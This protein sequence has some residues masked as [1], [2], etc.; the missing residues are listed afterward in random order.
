MSRTI[1]CVLSETARFHEVPAVGLY[2][3]AVDASGAGLFAGSSFFSV[4]Q[5]EN[6]RPRGDKGG[7]ERAEQHLTGVETGP[8]RPTRQVVNRTSDRPP[9]RASA[10]SQSPSASQ[11]TGL[12][13]LQELNLRP[14]H[15]EKSGASSSWTRVDHFGK[16]AMLKSD[17]GNSVL[18]FL[19]MA[20]IQPWDRM[21]AV[22]HRIWSPRMGQVQ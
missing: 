20:R 22:H 8:V 14:V 12:L 5:A 6:Q 1:R 4:V 19:S 16:S 11:G 9:D 10:M 2:R 7:Q 3:V 21:H 18:L 13:R 17:R 15:A